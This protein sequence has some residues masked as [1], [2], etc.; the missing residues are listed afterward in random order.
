MRS[1]LVKENPIGSAVTEIFR[2]KQTDTQTDTHTDRHTDRQTHRQTAFLAVLLVHFSIFKVHIALPEQN[3][4][5]IMHNFR[6]SKKNLRPPGANFCAS[7]G[8][9]L[10]FKFFVNQ[11]NN[12][13]LTLSINYHLSWGLKSLKSQYNTIKQV[14][15]LRLINNCDIMQQN[16]SRTHLLT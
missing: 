5:K 11:F 6:Y 12:T 13:M 4:P 16:C 8:A 10:Y 7:L 1:Y 9:I 15:Q 2:Y 3:Q 14:L